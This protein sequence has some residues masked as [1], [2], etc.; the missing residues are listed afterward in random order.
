[1]RRKIQTQK[2]SK[3]IENIMEEVKWWLM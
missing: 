2:F 1:L 3:I